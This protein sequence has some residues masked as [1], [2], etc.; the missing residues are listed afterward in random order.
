MK[1]RVRI[2]DMIIDYGRP[3][4]A[5]VVK[6]AVQDTINNTRK[7]MMKEYKV[8]YR[9]IIPGKL[10][11]NGS[12]ENDPQY[13]VKFAGRE[14]KATYWRKVFYGRE[15]ATMRKVMPAFDKYFKVVEV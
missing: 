5:A 13:L 14:G 12:A 7:E 10:M 6:K 15:I 3:R 4:A 8:F 9:D 2:I 11:A 1:Q